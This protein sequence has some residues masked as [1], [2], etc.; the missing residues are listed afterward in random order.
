MCV[1]SSFEDNP[2]VSTIVGACTIKG[3][4]FFSRS[5]DV[6]PPMFDGPCSGNQ[7]LCKSFFFFRDPGQSPKVLDAAVPV[8]SYV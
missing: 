3:N 4:T 6:H 5:L 8:G 7:E 2:N 1:V